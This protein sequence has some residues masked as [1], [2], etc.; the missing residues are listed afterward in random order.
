M[1]HARQAA[2]EKTAQTIIKNLGKR[3]ME[4]Y[5]CAT[6]ADAVELVKQLVPAGAYVTWGGSETLAET[7]VKDLLLSGAYRVIDRAAATTPEEK[8]AVW[9]QRTCADYHF[10]SANAL[11]VGGE[12]VN[13]DGNADRL[14][15]LL[16]GPEHVIMLVGANKIVAD[17]DE[18]VKRIRT[19][20]CPPNAARLHTNTPC[21]LT[22]VCAE[23]HAPQC[24]CCQIVVTRHSRHDGRIKVIL[25]G[26]DLG[27]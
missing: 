17:V 9:Q 19:Y 25:I 3:N 22:G 10:M 18:G 13:I 15:L 12:I 7:G 8:R 26:E 14:S 23:C 24:M 4:G 16:H 11:T 1:H 20:A 6:S 21:E 5:Y 27:F 2:F